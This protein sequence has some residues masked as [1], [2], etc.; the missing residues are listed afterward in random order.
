[1]RREFGTALLLGAGCGSL[2]LAIVWLWR[3][4]PGAAAV[5]AASVAGSLCIAC[6]AGVVM[7]SLL[8]ALR[9]D[10]KIAVGPVTLAVADVLTLLL[11]FSLA[12]WLL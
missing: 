6:L 10:P 2:V 8:H 1:M 7:P 3:R 11:Y 9:L 12:R 5:I 4:T